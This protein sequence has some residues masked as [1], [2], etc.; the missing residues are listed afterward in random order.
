MIACAADQSCFQVSHLLRTPYYDRGTRRRVGGVASTGD[1]RYVRY[2]DQVCD[3]DY[4]K[5]QEKLECV[6]G[7]AERVLCSQLSDVTCL[8]HVG[9]GDAN[10]TSRSKHSFSCFNL[11]GS[12]SSKYKS[13]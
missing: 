4:M 5:L 6:P 1:G 13:I 3:G 10:V 7:G 12:S 11:T 9:R 2:G 8:R